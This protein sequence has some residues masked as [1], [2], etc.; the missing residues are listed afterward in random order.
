[1]MRAMKIAWYGLVELERDGWFVWPLRA[2]LFLM[3]FVGTTAGVMGTF[4][5][6]SP[7]GVYGVNL[8]LSLSIGGCAAGGGVVFYGLGV[9]VAEG[10]VESIGMYVDGV[11]KRARLAE[12]ERARLVERQQAQA[13][14]LMLLEEKGQDGEQVHRVEGRP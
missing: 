4:D 9:L 12:L 1:M 7:P 6:I 11:A 14:A 2:L 8:L 3:V 5:G 13:G 10:A